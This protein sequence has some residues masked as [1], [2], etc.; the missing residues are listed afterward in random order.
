MEQ[1][2][3]PPLLLRAGLTGHRPNRLNIPLTHLCTQ[4][5]AVLASMERAVQRVSSEQVGLYRAQPA[6]LRFTTG[7][8]RGSDEA[9]AQ[10][11]LHRQ[12][13]LQSV[14]AFDRQTF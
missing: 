8:A 7:L 11:A 12:W 5:D 3:L 2:L 14:I 1:F 9:G 13:Q 6:A 4:V 10:V